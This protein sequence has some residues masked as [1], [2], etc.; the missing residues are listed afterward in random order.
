M[1][2]SISD[3]ISQRK[4]FVSNTYQFYAQHS[5]M[6]DEIKSA[7][8]DQIDLD[9]EEENKIWTK[10]QK[11][12]LRLNNFNSEIQDWM[13]AQKDKNVNQKRI[14]EISYLKSSFE[15][16]SESAEKH[17][18]IYLN[19]LEKKKRK[20][21]EEIALYFVRT[22]NQN[23]QHKVTKKEIEDNLDALKD[24]SEKWNKSLIN[25]VNFLLSDVR[26]MMGFCEEIIEDIDSA[27][28]TESVD[29]ISADPDINYLS[30][31]KNTAVANNCAK[32]SQQ[33]NNF[34]S[35]YDFESL[36]SQLNIN[37]FTLRESFVDLFSDSSMS[38]L[39]ASIKI[40]KKLNHTKEKIINIHQKMI[41][42]EKTFCPHY[43][44][45]IERRE[46]MIQLCVTSQKLESNTAF[47]WIEANLSDL[48]APLDKKIESLK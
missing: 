4:Q 19:S 34:Q 1:S 23:S 31:M 21:K 18:L 27:K 6:L 33:L 16:Q 29:M 14:I 10:W 26:S 5:M 45:L 48:F 3:I 47:K 20:W 22:I 37:Y 43:R 9:L 7:I 30:T 38:G 44:F 42:I 32:L 28:S 11:K 25:S 2:I 39:R 41:E 24:Y 12:L 17:Y 15:N 36:S 40:I 46:K 35:I 8:I 13:K